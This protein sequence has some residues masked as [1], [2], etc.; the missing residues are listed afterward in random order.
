MRRLLLFVAL[1]IPSSARAD[2]GGLAIGVALGDPSAI[3][4]RYTLSPDQLHVDAALGTGTLAGLGPELHAGVAFQPSRAVPVYV[5]LGLRYYHHGYAA[6]SVD[7]L[8]DDHVGV[9]AA[10][11]ATFDLSSKLELFGE[12]APGYDVHRSDSCSL[13][14][15]VDSIC[16]HAQSSPWF[17]QLMAGVRWSL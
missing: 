13:M 2:D 15:G 4:A 9:R 1:A 7:E 3:T 5:G 12:L 16:P 17:A 10:V 8:P 14:S 11:G 6:A